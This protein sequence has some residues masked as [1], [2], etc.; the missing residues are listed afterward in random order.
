MI[1]FNDSL[2]Y[3][4]LLFNNMTYKSLQV[5]GVQKY[6]FN[7]NVKYNVQFAAVQCHKQ[8]EIEYKSKHQNATTFM[9]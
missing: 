2:L 7:M 6:V 1:K 4:E 5:D 9:S 3:K 8:I